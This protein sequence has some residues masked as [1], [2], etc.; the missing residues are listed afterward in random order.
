MNTT[1]N[2]DL[3]VSASGSVPCRPEKPGLEKYRTKKEEGWREK[4]RGEKRGEREGRRGK[5]KTRSHL[6]GEQRWGLLWVA[7][8]S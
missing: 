4:E 2:L 1:R 7:C 6:R 5:V 8:V 3:R